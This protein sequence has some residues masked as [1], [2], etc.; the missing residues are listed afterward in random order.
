MSLCRLA[1]IWL[2]LT[3]TACSWQETRPPPRETPAVKPP[4][5]VAR[6]NRP[7]SARHEPPASSRGRYTIDQ[8]IGPDASEVPADIMMIPDAIPMHEPRSRGGNGPEY[9]V[10]GETYVVK[11]E[12]HGYRENGWASWYG[13]KFHGHLTANGETYDMFAMTGAHKTLP[14]PSYVRVTHLEN[15]KSVIVRINDRGPF[16][17]GRII[18]LSYAAAARLGMLKHGSAR[19]QVEAVLPG[20][21]ASALGQV[22]TAPTPTIRASMSAPPDRTPTLSANGAPAGYWQAG[23]FTVVANANA[24]Y[25]ALMRTALRPVSIHE[26]LRGEQRWHRVVVGPFSSKAEGESARQSLVSNGL[27]PQWVITH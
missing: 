22:A 19:V 23:A 3:L 4:V 17:D 12:S 20:V 7:S 6:P 2:L 13:K 8:D 27:N 10:F 16:H 24:L 5:A 26:L 11:D 1:V 21:P 18:D 25:D 15:G 9:T 14:I